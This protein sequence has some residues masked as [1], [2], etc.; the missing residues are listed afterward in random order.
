[1]VTPLQENLCS[2]STVPGPPAIRIS[3]LCLAS[4]AAHIRFVELEGKPG[5]S[6]GGLSLVFFS[7]KE[8]KAHASIPLEGTIGATGLLVF[9]LDGEHGHGKSDRMDLVWVCLQTHGQ[10]LEQL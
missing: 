7:G 2:S 6:L 3:E 9:V 1:M 5:T 8:G 4:G 10:G